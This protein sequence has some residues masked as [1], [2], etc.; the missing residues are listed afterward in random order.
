MEARSASRTTVYPRAYGG[1]EYQEKRRIYDQGLS[2]RVR[3]NPPLGYLVAEQAGS[4]PARTGEPGCA[5]PWL[6]VS[7]VYPRAYGGTDLVEDAVVVCQGLSPRVRG[8]RAAHA[9]GRVMLGSIPACAGEPPLLIATTASSRV[10]PRAYGGTHGAG[11]GARCDVGLSPRVRGNHRRRLDHVGRT[12]SIPARTG[13]PSL[14]LQRARWS[15]VY[16]RAYGGT[17][18]RKARFCARSGLSP[19]VRGNPGPAST[20]RISAGSIPARTGEPDAGAC[21]CGPPTVYPR[22]YGGTSG[23]SVISSS[24]TGLSPR[25]RGNPGRT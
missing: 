18:W 12:G 24:L 6:A 15:E 16:P 8:N 19:R 9:M 20:A 23:R 2:P 5:E 14:H 25:V 1:T 10:Y 22:A 4:I 17:A 11:V 21:P 13:E 3:G 7:R